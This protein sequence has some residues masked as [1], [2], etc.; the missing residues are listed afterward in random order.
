MLPVLSKIGGEAFILFFEDFRMKRRQ[1][2]E[3]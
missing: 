1:V 3:D 2:S